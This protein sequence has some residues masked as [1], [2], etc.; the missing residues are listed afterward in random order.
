MNKDIKELYLK[1][2]RMERELCENKQFKFLTINDGEF[3][4]EKMLNDINRIIELIDEPNNKLIELKNKIIERITRIKDINNQLSYI[5]EKMEDNCTHEIQINRK[6]ILCQ[7]DMMSRLIYD[8]NYPEYLFIIDEPIIPRS[9]RNN[10]C[11]IIEESFI[12]NEDY[13]PKIEQYLDDLEK[14][15]KNYTVKTLIRRPSS[16]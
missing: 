7:N 1:R 3:N 13:S 8:C 12:N 4:L 16:K 15:Q 2:R 5:K 9:F 14:E 11:N 6:C 10:I